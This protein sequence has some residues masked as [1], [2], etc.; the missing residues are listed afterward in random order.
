MHSLCGYG[1]MMLSKS[2][3]PITFST[4]L[5]LAYVKPTCVATNTAWVRILLRVAEKNNKHTVYM[6]FSILPSTEETFDTQHD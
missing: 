3:D 6:V 5:R 4:V 2:L 1:K